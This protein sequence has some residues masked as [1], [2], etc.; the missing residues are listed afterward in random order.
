RDD[1][2]LPVAV[3]ALH[4][5][6]DNVVPLAGGP[7]IALKTVF[8]DVSRSLEPFRKAGGDVQLRIIASAGHT[9]MTRD[10]NGVDATRAL[11]DFIRD[12]PRLA[13]VQVNEVLRA[14]MR[15]GSSTG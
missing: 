15:R 10:A 4:G 11:W 5:A 3:L 13:G 14:T 9:W 2:Q 7:N 12:H 1:P 8:P 6:R